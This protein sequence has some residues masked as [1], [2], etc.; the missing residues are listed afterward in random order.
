MCSFNDFILNENENGI[1]KW[2]LMNLDWLQKYA[3]NMQNNIQM[4][5]LIFAFLLGLLATDFLWP[6][7]ILYFHIKN[8]EFL[9]F[10]I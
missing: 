1:L 3:Q 10:F 4:A 7:G 5:L 9:I 8:N 6:A 2:L